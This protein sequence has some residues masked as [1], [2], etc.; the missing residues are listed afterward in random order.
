MKKTDSI[1]V[2]MEILGDF[3][4]TIKLADV[5]RLLNSFYK[6]S[7]M[8]STNDSNVISKFEFYKDVKNIYTYR[9]L[10]AL[11]NRISQDFFDYKIETKILS[12]KIDTKLY[13][14]LCSQT[15]P[16]EAFM[17]FNIQ[18]WKILVS[19]LIDNLN[20]RNS[21]YF[22]SIRILKIICDAIYVE[23]K[24]NHW[25]CFLNDLSIWLMYNGFKPYESIKE[26]KEGYVVKFNLE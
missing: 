13:E 2:T 22:V 24:T 4:Q 15:M 9:Q 21:S 6:L 23:Y 17:F 19:G 12:A 8:F 26:E 10:S 18:I 11:I 1:Y 20:S 7:E 25:N 14:D 16:I 3:R 5:I